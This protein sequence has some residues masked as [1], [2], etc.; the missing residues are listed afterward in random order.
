[1][2]YKMLDAPLVEDLHKI[3]VEPHQLQGCDRDLLDSC[4]RR[5]VNKIHYEGVADIHEAAAVVVESVAL[6]HSFS[7]GD[8]RTSL[9]SMVA[10]Y[11]ANQTNPP[12][13]FGTGI[14]EK[15]EALVK[16]ELSVVQL[17]AW[18]RQL[19]ILTERQL[20]KISGESSRPVKYRGP[21]VNSKKGRRS[22]W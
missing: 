16:D 9:L 19:P 15:I 5:L 7:D 20:R 21:T 14:A 10:F 12:N 8:K 17:A 13:L 11:F 4:L 6:G 3:I 2:T 18:L 1:M 22:R